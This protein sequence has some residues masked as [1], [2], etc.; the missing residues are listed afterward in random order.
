MAIELEFLNFIVPLQTIRSKYPGGLTQCLE[1][2]QHLLGGRVW[3][4]Q[5]LF[6]NGSM[7]WRDMEERIKH[8]ESMGF[9]GK[10]KCDGQEY[11]QD[12]CVADELTGPTLPCAWLEIGEKRWIAYLKG[13]EPGVLVGRDSLSED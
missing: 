2:H 4:D 5:H 1:D 6:R 7:D 3:Y 13:T 12:F 10:A 8:W 11:W 9:V